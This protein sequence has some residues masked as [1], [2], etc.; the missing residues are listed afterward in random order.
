MRKTSQTWVGLCLIK[1]YKIVHHKVTF[2][3]VNSITNVIRYNNSPRRNLL[4][5]RRY[6]RTWNLAEFQSNLRAPISRIKGEKSVFI[7][8]AKS[9]VGS[10]LRTGEA[11]YLH[12]NKTRRTTRSYASVRGASRNET[13]E[14]P[15]ILFTGRVEFKTGF[16]RQYK[17]SSLVLLYMETY[18]CD[19]KIHIY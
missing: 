18:R 6:S 11:T 15:F 9:F 10:Y 12:K 4:S 14:L 3:E 16:I 19:W 7:Y 1:K 2:V 13:R 8:L 17:R 5:K